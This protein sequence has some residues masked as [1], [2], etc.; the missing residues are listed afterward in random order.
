MKKIKKIKKTLQ[1]KN[2]QTTTSAIWPKTIKLTCV[3]ILHLVKMRLQY[4]QHEPPKAEI[5]ALERNF[6]LKLRNL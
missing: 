3:Y 2:K 1:I 4:S 5:N 6:T